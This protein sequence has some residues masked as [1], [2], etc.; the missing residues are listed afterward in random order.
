LSMVCLRSHGHCSRNSSMMVNRRSKAWS[1]SSRLCTDMAVYA[2]PAIYRF[3]G[4]FDHFF[5]AAVFFPVAAFLADCFEAAVLGVADF[6]LDFLAVA[7]GVSGFSFSLV[8]FS[9]ASF[10]SATSSGSEKSVIP[11]LFNK[12]YHCTTFLI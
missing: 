10:S 12:L 4:L 3:H 7:F 9:V 8:C 6:G 1:C 2:E 11:F 5:L